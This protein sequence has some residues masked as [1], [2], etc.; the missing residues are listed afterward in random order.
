M[1]EIGDPGPFY[2]VDFLVTMT[3]TVVIEFFNRISLEATFEV[4]GAALQRGLRTNLNPSLAPGVLTL[5]WADLPV[6]KV[7]DRSW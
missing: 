5:P 7:H 4:S 1:C 2:E 6:G 3:S